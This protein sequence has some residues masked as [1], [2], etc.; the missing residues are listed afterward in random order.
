MGRFQALVEAELKCSE[1]IICFEVEID[2]LF[3]EFRRI[4]GVESRNVFVV[5]WVA[6]SVRFPE[7]WI[8]RGGL[9]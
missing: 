5:C 8:E 6:F 4:H 3:L 9:T 1:S 7:G 2:V